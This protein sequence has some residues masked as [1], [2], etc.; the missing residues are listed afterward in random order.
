MFFV[1]GVWVT[2][3]IRLLSWKVVIVISKLVIF[4]HCHSNTY[5]RSY[6]VHYDYISD[7]YSCDFTYFKGYFVISSLIPNFSKQHFGFNF[8][9]FDFGFNLIIAN[10]LFWILDIGLIFG[11][12][13]LDC[14]WALH[15]MD[16]ERFWQ[17]FDNSIQGIEYFTI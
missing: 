11:S 13:I 7:L 15:L 17:Q 6:D 12:Q 4:F 8:T 2:S 10:W 14:H 16:A 9:W 1:G 5:L 3:G